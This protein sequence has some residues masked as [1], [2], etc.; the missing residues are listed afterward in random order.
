M[1]WVLSSVIKRT[2][3]QGGHAAFAGRDQNRGAVLIIRRIEAR[4]SARAKSERRGI[5]RAG[6][7][8]RSS[9][10]R[11]KSRSAGGTIGPTQVRYF[12]AV[13]LS[14]LRDRH[15]R[16]NRSACLVRST[17]RVCLGAIS[18]ADDGHLHHVDIGSCTPRL[19]DAW[20]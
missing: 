20:K 6:Q 11:V 19:V 13:D 7:G 18:H 12:A 4:L 3:G 1:K 14:L 17:R 15:H 10:W 16:E 5:T 8:R 9:A 2:L